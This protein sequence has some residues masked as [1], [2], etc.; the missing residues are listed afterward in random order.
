MN[1]KVII[2]KVLAKLDPEK[3]MTSDKAME[4]IFKNFVKKEE[5]IK[6]NY[7]KDSMLSK[8]QHDK[9][10]KI[11]DEAP[12]KQL[13]SYSFGRFGFIIEGIRFDVLPSSIEIKKVK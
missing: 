5:I 10:R 12:V 13:Y 3:S 7:K 6:P 11:Y 8:E 9:L 4:V 2:R 1:R